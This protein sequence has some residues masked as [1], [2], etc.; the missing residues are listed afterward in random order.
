MKDRKTEVK[1]CEITNGEE[2]KSL[3]VYSQFNCIRCGAKSHDSAYLCEPET[4]LGM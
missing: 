1:I 3:S 4:F 2:L